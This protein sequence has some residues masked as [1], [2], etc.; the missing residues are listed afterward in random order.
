[1]Q[2][3]TITFLTQVLCERLR[4]RSFA[5]DWV[6]SSRSFVEY[7]V[8]SSA[9]K[10]VCESGMNNLVCDEGPLWKIEKVRLWRRSFG[11]DW[12]SSSVTK[13]LCERLS[14]LVKVLCERL[15]KFVCDEGPLRKTDLVSLRRRSFERDW[16]RWRSFLR[17]VIPQ[18]VLYY[19]NNHTCEIIDF[20]N[21]GKILYHSILYNKYIYN[22][23]Y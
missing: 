18:L 8:S 13:V 10:V 12:L 6:S 5:K 9:T 3:E 21:G 20:I 7:R 15:R 19:M 11:K 2:R 17:N 14:K 23:H 4:R 1:M 22:T 16:V